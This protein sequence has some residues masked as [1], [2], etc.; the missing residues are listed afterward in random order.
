MPVLVGR[1][2]GTGSN[3]T[4]NLGSTNV[5]SVLILPETGSPARPSAG[6]EQNYRL[7]PFLTGQQYTLTSGSGANIKSYTITCGTDS[8][9]VP[10][11]LCS[12]SNRTYV[13]IAFVYEL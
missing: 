5:G 1:Y 13:W 3:Y 11:S 2:G 8:M 9:T 6:L 10:A 4:I 12:E 7:F